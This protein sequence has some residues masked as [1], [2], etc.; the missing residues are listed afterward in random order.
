MP[1]DE[2]TENETAVTELTIAADGRVYVFGTSLSVLEILSTL[3]PKD[4]RLAARL[5][6]VEGDSSVLLEA[7]VRRAHVEIEGSR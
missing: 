4:E 2:A 5:K 3:N 1:S 6:P 7:T